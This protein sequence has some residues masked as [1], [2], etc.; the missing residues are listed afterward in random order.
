VVPLPSL[1]PATLVA[2]AIARASFAIALFLTISLFITIAI[3]L[4]T[5]AITLFVA[6]HPCY[7][8]HHHPLC[9]HQHLSPTTLLDVAITLLPLSSLLPTIH[10]AVPIDL[11]T[12]AIA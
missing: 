7:C 12:L 4:A 11:A 9:C 8:C 1:L 10:I 6:C 3:A 2:I 5:L